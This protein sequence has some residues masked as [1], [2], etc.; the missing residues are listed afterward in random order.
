MTAAEY[1]AYQEQQKE[2]QK[3]LYLPI[4]AELLAAKEAQERIMSEPTKEDLLRHKLPSNF[5]LDEIMPAILQMN[6]EEMR[7][8]IALNDLTGQC[9]LNDAKAD[10]FERVL[11]SVSKSDIKDF[12]ALHGVGSLGRQIEVGIKRTTAEV[13]Q[14]FTR[15]VAHGASFFSA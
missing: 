10:A 4:A 7:L 15:R 5:D 12:M 2:A 14:G 1:L 9:R 8:F 11:N 13:A 3:R 6:S